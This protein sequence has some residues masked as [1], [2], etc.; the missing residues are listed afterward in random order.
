MTFFN[1]S[2]PVFPPRHFLVPPLERV[3]LHQVLKLLNRGQNCSVQGP[4]HSGKTTFL[5]ALAEHLNQPGGHVLSDYPNAL[6]VYVN[7]AVA[8][9]ADTLLEDAFYALLTE[10]ALRAETV[11]GDP[12]PAEQGPLLLSR[13]GPRAGLRALL[14]AWARH[15]GQPLVLLLD[16]VDLLSPETYICMMAQLRAGLGHGSEPYT[17][18]V[19]FSGVFA[20]PP[21]L[22][23]DRLD[24]V[25][26]ARAAVQGASLQLPPFSLS[27]VKK[28]LA[29]HTKTGGR[30]FTEEAVDLIWDLT[31]GH[32]WLV[33]SLA[34]EAAEHVEGTGASMPLITGEQVAEARERLL[35]RRDPQMA[36][37]A[38]LLHLEPV[39]QVVEPLLGGTQYPACLPGESLRFCEA[40]G[41]VTVGSEIRIANRI[42]QEWVPRALTEGDFYTFECDTKL[43]VNES[44]GTLRM[45]ELLRQCQ[46]RFRVRGDRL[47]GELT[48]RQAGPLLLLQAFVSRIVTSQG[49]IE[50]DY[51]HNKGRVMLFVFWQA[52]DQVQTIVLQMKIL[53]GSPIDAIREG[54]AE[55]AG[56]MELCNSDEGHLI[57]FDAVPGRIMDARYF[58]KTESYHG[59][60]IVMWGM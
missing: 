25:L 26:A 16:G 52:R 55:T 50:R 23:P 39:R 10:L 7:L 15:R 28:L 35:V 29:G 44:H 4:P 51:G 1:T 24:S 42:L 56:F 38:R 47:L 18:A 48:Y 20:E 40:L 32:P 59:K 43:L 31:Q 41:L 22:E 60:N 17:L 46:E 33:N 34:V 5:L 2:G 12:F 37:L 27:Q 19:V 3:D 36:R 13:C 8:G 53:N 11:L 45:E 21:P 57:L 6:A 14:Q 9:G 30:K 58:S 49:R 54:L